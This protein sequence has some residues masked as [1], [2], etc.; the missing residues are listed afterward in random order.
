MILIRPSIAWDRNGRKRDAVTQGE[1]ADL[2]AEGSGFLLLVGDGASGGRRPFVDL[3]PI[4][5]FACDLTANEA[6][7][8]EHSVLG[9]R[10]ILPGSVC[11]VAAANLDADPV[12]PRSHCSR[13]PISGACVGDE[14]PM[15]T[16]GKDQQGSDAVIGRESV[17]IGRFVNLIESP[18]GRWGTQRDERRALRPLPIEGV[19]D[20]LPGEIARARRSGRSVVGPSP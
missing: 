19:L 7:E 5:L 12:S 11:R 14:S 13:S 16:L 10:A 4:E 17:E 1:T 18:Q 20:L 2:Q 15:D 8:A 6:G 3:H 9:W